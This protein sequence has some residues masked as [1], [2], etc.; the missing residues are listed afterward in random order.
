MILSGCAMF[1]PSATDMSEWIFPT[2]SFSAEKVFD[3]SGFFDPTSPSYSQKEYDN[4]VSIFGSNEV[5]QLAKDPFH[6]QPVRYV[7]FET[8]TPADEILFYY[9][10]E[11]L[12]NGW[13]HV[14]DC[15]PVEDCPF[16]RP[17]HLQVWRKGDAMVKLRIS[18][19]DADHEPG[20]TDGLTVHE[21][22]IGFIGMAPEALLGTN[23]RQKGKERFS[24]DKHVFEP[25]INRRWMLDESN[26]RSVGIVTN[27]PNHQP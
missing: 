27:V 19:G 7:A 5:A 14:R 13:T 18:D 6:S 8:Y 20:P 4:Y 25:M 17:E 3:Y 10:R 16:G 15:L 23:Y 12:W 11:F 9:K 2:A 21:I 24:T 22:A 26:R 1:P